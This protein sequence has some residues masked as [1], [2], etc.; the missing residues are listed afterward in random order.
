MTRFTRYEIHSDVDGYV[1]DRE[2][3]D[4]AQRRA[5]ELDDEHPGQ[6][7]TVVEVVEEY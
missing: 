6:T 2:D 7:H 5:T 3:R 1:T 4:D